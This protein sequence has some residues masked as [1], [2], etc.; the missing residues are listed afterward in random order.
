MVEGSSANDTYLLAPGVDGR[1]GF[2]VRATDRVGVAG[3]VLALFDPDDDL[4]PAIEHPMELY[5]G[6]PQDGTWTTG[7]N[8]RLPM[9]AGL[10]KLRA[11]ALDAA[12]N[13]SG[14][15]TRLPPV[16][17]TFWVKRETRL[18]APRVGLAPGRPDAVVVRARLEGAAAHRWVGLERRVVRVE[19]RRE[20]RSRWV[21]Q[22][23][24][25]A[26]GSTYRK[27]FRTTVDGEWRVRFDGTDRLAPVKGPATF[28][29]AG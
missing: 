7:F 9:P 20:G 27:R 2:A 25:V 21:D 14:P 3:V 24:L 11:F 19:F 15:L 26:H 29:D 17:D 6:T 18:D 1:M 16:L 4:T 22:G 8:V 5:A 12:G 13:V 23:P 10:W 28:V